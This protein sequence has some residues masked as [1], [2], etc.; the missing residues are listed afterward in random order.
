MGHTNQRTLTVGRAAVRWF[1][2][3]AFFHLLPVPWFMV[4]VAG[5]AAAGFLFAIGVA[6]L[7]VT[8]FDSLPMAV[9][10]F[11]KTLYSL[12]T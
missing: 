1:I 10:F 12:W 7:F 8:D 9:M 11:S 5:P 2:F 6:G 3:L 4:V